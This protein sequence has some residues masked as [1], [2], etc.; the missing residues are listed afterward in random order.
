MEKQTKDLSFKNSKNKLSGSLIGHD[1]GPQT[2]NLVFATV[3]K[4]KLPRIL[5]RVTGK[6]HVML[7][8]MVH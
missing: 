8:N 4:R 1:I 7:L 2:E 3:S 5:S 6:I